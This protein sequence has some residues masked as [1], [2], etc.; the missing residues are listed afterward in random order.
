MMGNPGRSMSRLPEVALDARKPNR[1]VLGCRNLRRPGSDPRSWPRLLRRRSPRRGTGHSAVRRTGL[2]PARQLPRTR[3]R[4]PLCRD[5]SRLRAESPRTP[6]TPAFVPRVGRPDR[7]SAQRTVPRAMPA[8]WPLY[9]C[10]SQAAVLYAAA[11]RAVDAGQASRRYVGVAAHND[12]QGSRQSA[13]TVAWRHQG[14]T[15]RVFSTALAAQGPDAAS[16]ACHYPFSQ[17]PQPPLGVVTGG[18][19]QPDRQQ[20]LTVLVALGQKRAGSLRKQCPASIVRLVRVFSPV[21]TR[22]TALR[23]SHCAH[24]LERVVRLS[25]RRPALNRSPRP[26]SVY[27]D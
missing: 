9:W 12:C 13:A 18:C 24:R 8:L 23:P 20:I 22:I 21:A 15:R 11:T 14:V 1:C 3:Q 5:P 19:V 6:A 17:Q 10:I 4:E 7:F 27:R 16:A 26:T 2:E 25:S